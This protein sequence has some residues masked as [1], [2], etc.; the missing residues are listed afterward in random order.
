MYYSEVSCN[1]EESMKKT[2]Q[3]MHKIISGLEYNGIVTATNH[4]KI[5][6]EAGESVSRNRIVFDDSIRAIFERN[7]DRI[8]KI[9][10]GIIISKAYE[11]EICYYA[12]SPIRCYD[13]YCVFAIYARV[14][15]VFSEKELKTM[16]YL[17]EITYEN[18]V[19]NHK[20][21]QERNYLQNIFNSTKSYILTFDLEERVISLNRKTAKLFKERDQIIGSKLDAFVTSSTYET[22]RDLYYKVLESKKT[23]DGEYDFTTS[24]N[25]KYYVNYTMS[26]MFDGKGVVIGVVVLFVDVTKQKIYEREIE[27]LRQYAV[28]SK[29]A[30]EIAHDIKNPLMGIRGCAELMKRKVSVELNESYLEPIIDEVDRIRKKLNPL[31]SYSKMHAENNFKYMDIN[32]LLDGCIDAISCYRSMKYIEVVKI[33]D[34]D[35]PPIEAA[36]RRVSQAFFN[37]FL[38]AIDAIGNEGII[39]V[40]T[41]KNEKKRMVVIEISDN[42]IGIDKVN[43]E[44]IKEPFFTTKPEGTGLGL[45]IV[46]RVIEELDGTVDFESELG[47]GTTVI[48][49]L[50]YDDG[51]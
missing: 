21:I 39:K 17:T 33:Y 32:S 50:P 10:K 30:A 24:N 5:I 12:I 31:L 27:Q 16:N 20:V 4:G 6:I 7:L 42:G 9:D 14:G 11:G 40:V 26:P 29:T 41:R 35:L 34:E 8:L 13:N 15:S 38:N 19:L 25:K 22:F 43:M 45:S 44:R 1:I 51:R 28:L 3:H 46:K 18:I 2:R 48:M 37:I 47:K 23:E 49:N 36:E